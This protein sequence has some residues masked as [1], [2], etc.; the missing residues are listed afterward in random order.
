MDHSVLPLSQSHT[1]GGGGSVAAV[2]P[3]AGDQVAATWSVMVA[4]ALVLP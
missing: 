3:A 2:C 1:L 4:L